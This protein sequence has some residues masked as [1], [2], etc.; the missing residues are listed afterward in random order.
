MCKMAVPRRRRENERAW[1]RKQESKN[2]PQHLSAEGGFAINWLIA[3]ALSGLHLF[4]IATDLFKVQV[5]RVV[6]IAIRKKVCQDF[7]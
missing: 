4:I 5:Y 1:M 3:S 7:F 2:L 6:I